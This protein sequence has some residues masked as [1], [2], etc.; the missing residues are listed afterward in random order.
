M[1]FDYVQNCI[2]LSKIH[3]ELKELSNFE[4][5]CFYKFR[6][7]FH[8]LIQETFFFGK[9]VFLYLFICMYA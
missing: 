8:G 7:N 3:K 4:L 6:S 2:D 1:F 5:L 9:A